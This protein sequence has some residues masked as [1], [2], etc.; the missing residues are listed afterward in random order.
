M[1]DHPPLLLFRGLPY[2]PGDFP[3]V[4]EASLPGLT[5]IAAQQ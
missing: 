3:T 1:I 4:Q 5:R 2:F